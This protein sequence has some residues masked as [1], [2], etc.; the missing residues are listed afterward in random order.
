V[1]LAIVL[2]LV[3]FYN[4]FAAKEAH[5]CKFTGNFKTFSITAINMPPSLGS[6]FTIQKCNISTLY[7]TS[8]EK[9]FKE[10]TN[11]LIFLLDFVGKQ[12]HFSGSKPGQTATLVS[13]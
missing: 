12:R 2:S 7:Y 11:L 3:F 5:F 9:G 8:S 10:Y 6:R 4:L 13:C 1:N